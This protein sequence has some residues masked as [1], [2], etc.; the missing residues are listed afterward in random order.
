MADRWKVSIILEYT[1]ENVN[2]FENTEYSIAY[3]VDQYSMGYDFEKIDIVYMSDPKRSYKDIIQSIGR[4]MRPD[5][6]GEYGKNL[7]NFPLL[8]QCMLY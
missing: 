6:K 3:V 1:Y 7:N 2:T 4:G 8:I 5:K